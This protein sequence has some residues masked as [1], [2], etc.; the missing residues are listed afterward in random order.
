MTIAAAACGNEEVGDASREAPMAEP[1]AQESDTTMMEDTQ[2]GS[3]DNQKLEEMRAQFARVDM[4]PD[5]SFLSESEREV[6]NLL[7]DA[8]ELM[9]EIY[10]RQL[11]ERNPE[12]REEIAGSETSQREQLLD[13]FDLH[14]GVWDGLDHN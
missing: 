1:S 10:L 12:W 5:T 13:L 9:D 7:I 3:V 8:A 6:M 2:A 4:N 11:S 14:F